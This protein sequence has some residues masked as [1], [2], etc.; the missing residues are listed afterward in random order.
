MQ[1]EDFR[2]FPGRRLLIALLRIG[3]VAGVVGV[4]AAVL[5]GEAVTGV[6]LSLLGGSGLGIALLDAYADRAYLRQT[7]GLAVMLKAALLAM[8]LAFAAFGPA[9]F[10]GLLILSV[11]VAHAPGR[12]RHRKLV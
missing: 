10:W 3:H 5:H 6:F 4:G 11:A 8:L 12:V 7:N 2:D 9:A 1:G